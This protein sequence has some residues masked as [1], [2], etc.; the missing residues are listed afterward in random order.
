M[1]SIRAFG[2]RVVSQRSLNN[3]VFTVFT[4]FLS[5]KICGM[6]QMPITS[7][8]ENKGAF[9]YWFTV[10]KHF[11]QPFDQGQTYYDNLFFGYSLAPY[12]SQSQCNA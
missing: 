4:L 6:L 7:F 11:K 12:I 5:I 2:R 8:D 10:V 9:Y 1:L 3:Q